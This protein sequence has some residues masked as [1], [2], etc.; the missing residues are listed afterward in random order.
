MPAT[1]TL[2]EV[3]DAAESLD[4]DSRV[5]L[6]SL[7]NKRLAESSRNRLIERIDEARAD[8]AAGRYEVMTAAEIVAEA[9]S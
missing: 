4:Y 6:V 3:L 5:E 7:L 1:V 9:M 2:D 8:F